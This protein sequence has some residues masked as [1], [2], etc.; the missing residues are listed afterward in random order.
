MSVKPTRE[1][2]KRSKG[3]GIAESTAGRATMTP[4]IRV[5]LADCYPMFLEGLKHTLAMDGRFEIV[6]ST[7]S[8]EEV[9]RY[10]VDLAPDIVVVEPKTRD[11]G[12]Q[13]LKRMRSENP[14]CR[15]VVLTQMSGIDD[16]SA[17]LGAGATGFILKGGLCPE[18]LLEA[19]V[20][21]AAGESFVTPKLAAGLI[22]RIAEKTRKETAVDGIESL[23]NREVQI[24]ERITVGKTNKEIARE[25][26]LSEKTIKHYV[27]IVLQKLHV[28][29]RLQAA[30]LLRQHNTREL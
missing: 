20:S 28:S 15:A 10:I 26:K 19:L 11:A 27:M 7:S 25:L 5:V 1:P 22:R 12:V 21:V 24:L 14:S 6:A 3:R 30:K 29:N 16:A 8:I 4:A 9:A 17:V 13:L 2:N 18:E 23:R